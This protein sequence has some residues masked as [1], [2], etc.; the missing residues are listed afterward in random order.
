MAK[1]QV[2]SNNEE[3]KPKAR[4]PTTTAANPSLISTTRPKPGS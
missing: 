1:G 2:K 3:R 4:N